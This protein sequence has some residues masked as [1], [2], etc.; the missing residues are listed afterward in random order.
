MSDCGSAGNKSSSHLAWVGQVALHKARQN[1]IRS[2]F[3]FLSKNDIVS[4]LEIGQTTLNHWLAS[5]KLFSVVNGSRLR[6]PF[7][8]IDSAS[9]APFPWVSDLIEMADDLT[10]WGL[11]YFLTASN[12]DLNGTARSTQWS[13]L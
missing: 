2:E 4:K 10:G 12:Q 3:E 8:Q 1:S 11:M 13:A 5:G 7:F 9:R 6:V